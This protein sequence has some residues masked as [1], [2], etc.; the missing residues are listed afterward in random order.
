MSKVRIDRLTLASNGTIL[1]MP[2]STEKCDKIFHDMFG[3]DPIKRTVEF[4]ME[5]DDK[6]QNGVTGNQ[7]YKLQPEDIVRV[8]FRMLSATIVAGGSWRA[9]DFSNEKVLRASVPLLSGVPAYQD[10]AQYGN[11]FI[12]S[13]ETT[14]WA[15]KSG[16]IPAGINGIYQVDG[17]NNPKLASGLLMEPPAIRANSVTVEFQWEPS[18]ELDSDDDFFN[19][20][21]TAGPDGKMVCRVVTKILAYYESS[22]LFMGADP[23]ASMLDDK[24]NPSHVDKGAV[25]SDMTQYTKNLYEKEKKY[26]ISCSFSKE[27]ISL[28]ADS[29]QQSDMKDLITL[30][31]KL[32]NLKDDEAITKEHFAKVTMGLNDKGEI[33]V[34]LSEG[35][36]PEEAVTRLKGELVEKEK[37]IT[38]LSDSSQGDATLRELNKTYRSESET[39][40]KANDKLELEAK[41]NEPMIALGKTVLE[42]KKKEVVDLYTKTVGADKADDAVIKLFNE[43]GSSEALDGLI[44]QYTKGVQAR[45]HA[46]CSACQSEEI[47]FRSSLTI[48]SGDPKKEIS[49]DK[50]E[51]NFKAQF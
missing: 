9:T 35:E 36:S 12:G 20:I 44:K 28:T 3:L 11:Y 14:I 23:F 16:D 39:L 10:H 19:K 33:E 5:A 25:Y 45:F 46:R 22:I 34:T 24:G 41:Q 31:K 49:D 27:P 7:K 32:L 15:P 38:S 21:G 6:A 37:T 8:P 13:V 18:H 47:E 17:K 26:F 4:K 30:I 50:F 29:N 51:E 48:E 40:Q 2:K 43:A 1:L 42:N